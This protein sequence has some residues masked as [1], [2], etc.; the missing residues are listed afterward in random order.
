MARDVEFAVTASDKTGSAL[1]AAEAKFKA[2]QERIRRE[3][4]TT[5][6]GMGKSL[7]DGIS[8]V[9][10]RLGGLLT[11]TFATAGKAGGPLLAAGIALATPLIGASVS[12]AVIGGAGAGG[13]LGGVAL[14]ARDPRVKAAGEALGKNL[15]GTL[16]KNAQA[17]FVEPVLRNI[18]KVENRFAQMETRINRIFGNS[19]AFLDPL[20]D[21]TLDAVDG[22]L[23]GIDALV[24]HA[25]PTMDALGDSIGLIGQALGEAFAT[26]AGGGDEAALTIRFL[27]VTVATTI[28]IFGD[29]V[30]ILTEVFGAMLA[31][32]KDALDLA[33]ALGIID[34]NT[35]GLAA[36]AGAA[37]PP[38]TQLM[39]GVAGIGTAA[40]S[41]A[42]PVA[43]FTDQVNNLATAGRTAFD[44]TTNVGEATDRVREALEKNGKTLDANTEKGRANRNAL[45]ALAAARLADYNATVQLNGEG[46][47]SNQVAAANRAAFIK[48]ATQFG[49]SKTAAAQL[50]TQFG[51]IPAKKNTTFHANTHDAE[52]RAKALAEKLDRAARTRTASVIVTFNES[53][54][55][56][57]E[58]RLNRLHGEGFARGD[59]WSAVDSSSGVARTGG[60][61]PVSVSSSVSVSLDGAPF[62]AMTVQAVEAGARRQ[63][64]RAKVGAR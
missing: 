15:L 34:K 38:T 36:S 46:I 53:R 4:K 2:S 52:A 47:K 9:S 63:A 7:L 35:I 1:A 20:V 24:A 28:K 6:D 48:L 19:S 31:G 60:P 56:A 54:I 11:S 41:A 8:K 3:S 40:T 25:G 14:A 23:R 17:S 42:T 21:G 59:G 62:R 50:A 29:A 61:T 39:A 13:V 57:V 5:G 18:A 51:L 43:T 45:S 44:A 12:A 58:N 27:G 30:R 55:R 22:I 33:A 16:E 64:W 32:A 10:P 37:V 26:I 49:L